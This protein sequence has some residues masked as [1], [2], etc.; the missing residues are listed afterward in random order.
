VPASDNPWDGLPQ[1]AGSE[2]NEQG[3][4]DTIALTRAGGQAPAQSAPKPVHNELKAVRTPVP[5]PT[6]ATEPGTDDESALVPAVP[7]ELVE[8]SEEHN[9]ACA[10]AES[11]AATEARQDAPL[12]LAP[13]ADR[14]KETPTST[15]QPALP[16]S[17]SGMFITVL[18]RRIGPLDRK[19]A[20]ALKAK[21]LKGQ[22]T[23]A[24][25]ADYPQ[26]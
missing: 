12:E 14:P 9:K 22:L 26:A 2:S 18:G 3:D 16:A 5:E 8:A 21:E 13:K 24:D 11:A 1:E 6:Q 10:E 7:K 23:E 20:K 19:E 17:S 25:L 15:T 4:G